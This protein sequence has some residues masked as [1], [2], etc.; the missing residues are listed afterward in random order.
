L[1]DRVASVFVPAVLLIGVITF[2]GW[3]LIA[4]DPVTGV[5][6]TVTVLIISCPCALGLATPMAVMVG[7][8]AASQRGILVKSA[9]ALER[10]GRA[11][12]I[13]FDKTGTLTRGTPGLGHVETHGDHAVDDVLRIAAA[14]EESSE[15]PIA[16][17]IVAAARKRNISIPASSNFRALPGVGVEAEVEG[18]HVVV[19]L[20][21]Q[22]TCRVEVE[23]ETVARLSLKDE[24]RDDAIETVEQLRA[25]DLTIHLL[26]GDK[27]SIALEIARELGLDA[28]SIEAEATPDSKVA[29]VK[30]LTQRQT[31]GKDNVVIM[32]GDGINDAAALA[33]ADLGIAMASGTNIAIESA[34]VVIPG[35][36]VAAVAETVDIARRTLRTIKQN[37]FFAFFYN[38]LAIPAAAFALLG[39]YGPMI[40]AAAMGFSDI[41]VIGNALRLKRKLGKGANGTN[42]R[43][44]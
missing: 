39:P 32:V 30:Q 10:A 24:L 19:R 9:L 17:A 7:S 43:H 25:M 23:G 5:V 38:V 33:E 12:H 2:L 34:G 1:A 44:K 41:T 3:W 18:K 20:D 27:S 37:L 31:D 4:G 21:E 14:A 40:A 36:R 29:F 35:D 6:A 42:N 28:G 16:R 8:G 13:V 11:T 26:T 15:H 22:A